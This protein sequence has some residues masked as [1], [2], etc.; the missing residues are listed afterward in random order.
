MS[1]M[2]MFFVMLAARVCSDLFMES[3]RD[4]KT[5]KRQLEAAKKVN[6]SIDR[7]KDALLQEPTYSQK[8]GN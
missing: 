2:E 5:Y 6:A 4:Y 3:Y 1:I 7:L 8:E